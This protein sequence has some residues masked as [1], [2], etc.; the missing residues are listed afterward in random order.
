MWNIAKALHTFYDFHLTEKGY[1]G[2]AKEVK[3]KSL[4]CIR[5][6]DK[7]AFGDVCRIVI[8][9]SVGETEETYAYKLCGDG[10][11][12]ITE[13]VVKEVNGKEEKQERRDSLRSKK[14]TDAINS[15]LV[16]VVR[17]YD[18]IEEIKL[19]R[20][21]DKT[22]LLIVYR[23]N[24]WRVSGKLTGRGIVDVREEQVVD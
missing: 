20:R 3:S 15:L 7:S 14:I 8:W 18:D 2:K 4:E 6:I 23:E 17:V 16:D 13:T 5:V 21:L 19:A 1:K 22:K 10:S 12:K 9:H 24:G 11:I